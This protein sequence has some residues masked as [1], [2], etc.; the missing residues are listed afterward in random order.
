MG[1]FIWTDASWF[2]W[3]SKYCSGAGTSGASQLQICNLA[4]LALGG[5]TIVSLSD[6]TLSARVMSTLW[7]SV[8]KD[9]LRDI[10]PNFARE[11]ADLVKSPVTP[12]Y[13]FANAFNL[14]ADCLKVI[15]MGEP[16]DQ[17]VWRIEGSQLLT[18]EAS[19]QILY[20]RYAS[21]P[22]FFD[23]KFVI[24][25]AYRLAAEAAD[26]LTGRTERKDA[27]MKF[28]ALALADAASVGS[29]EQT[30]E[31]QIPYRWADARL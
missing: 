18:N 27:M 16:E 20:V 3:S 5:A 24:A 7:P 8:L 1:W 17:Y 12:V 13:G 23:S 30:P 15:I 6:D 21:D 22:T 9:V 14:P 28:Y 25:F 19:A 10:S 11:R 31:D 2:V 29:Q 26:A 4:V